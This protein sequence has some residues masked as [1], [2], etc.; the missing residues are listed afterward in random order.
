MKQITL[1]LTQNVDNLGIVGDVV[2]VKAGYARNY[3]LPHGMAT[4]PTQGAIDR[5]A[6]ERARVEAEMKEVFAKQAAIIEKLEGHEI[7]MKRAANE[8]GLLFGGVSQ[9]EIALA[10]REDGFEIEDRYVRIGE[11]IKRLDSYEIPVV[12]NK[13]LKTHIKLWVVSDKP[14]EQLEAEAKEEE[15]RLKA[16]L[17]A[18]KAE[19]AAEEAAEFA[20]K[21]AK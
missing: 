21:K 16:E 11:Q 3:L 14:Q 1:L 2:K 7:T 8:Q 4:T 9:H 17:E 6:E 13:E 20:A 18:E 12:I 5:L 10:L 19:E 15:A